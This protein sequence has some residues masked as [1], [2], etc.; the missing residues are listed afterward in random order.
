MQLTQASKQ[1]ASRPDDERFT[2]LESLR[3]KVDSV[4]H[5]SKSGVMSNRDIEFQPSGDS[6]DGIQIVSRSGNV[7]SPTHWAFG[8]LATKA[9]APSEFLRT[10]PSPMTADILNL[11]LRIESP[12]EDLGVLVGY[13]ENG[14]AETMR[15]AT[16]PN[17]GRVWN[18][19]IAGS[20]VN[21]FGDGVSGAWKVP[22]EFGKDVTVTKDNT[23]L[24][25]SDRDMFCFLADEK[26]R[27]EIP[28]RRDGKTGSLARGFFVWNSE[29]GSQSFG[30]AAFLFDYAC[31]N[32]IVWGAN[33]YREMKFRHTAS[34]PDRWIESVVPMLAAYSE[35]SVAPYQAAMLAAQNKRLDDVTSF[36]ANRFSK[37]Q[38]VQIQA[39]HFA[40]ENR[41]IETVWDAVT[42]VTAFARN[43]KF[44]DERVTL[45]RSA[46]KIL[47]LVAA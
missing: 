1:W 20:L 43:V 4:K 26:N 23:T 17:Y 37:R 24:Y 10:L 22:G 18:S 5:R 25:A 41:P 44:Q 30:M 21:M 6:I 3:S 42:G 8:Q 45:E 9:K 40:D 33:E 28:N 36:L 46:G 47:D 31:S 15:A 27:I 2:S 16:G 14:V 35:S 11:K 34:A 7:I 19:D 12:I 39:A 32:R 29:V 13:D 38:A